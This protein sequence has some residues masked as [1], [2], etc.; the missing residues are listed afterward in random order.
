MPIDY[1]KYDP[2][3][4]TEIRPAVLKRAECCCEKCG[5]DNYA[6]VYWDKELK[7]WERMRGNIDCDAAGNGE[8][9][10]QDARL[11]ADLNNE[12]AGYK[13]WIV[14]VLT[15][16]HLNHDVTDNRMENL[17]ALCQRC[18]NNQ[19]K[20]YRRQNAKVTI[21]NKKGLQS[22]FKQTTND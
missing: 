13:V 21:N 8:C 20:E 6:V 16:A 14:I 12:S 3:W 15:I 19:E 10:Y 9:S 18:H 17:A 4:K 2:A 1:K 22:L 7:K 11:C 5:I